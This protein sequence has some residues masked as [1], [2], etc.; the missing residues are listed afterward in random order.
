MQPTLF[1]LPVPERAQHGRNVPTTHTSDPVTS[2]QADEHHRASGK[3]DRHRVLV[4]SMV[5][6]HP[7]N[8]ACELW[9]LAT[10]E[11]RSILGE[12]QEV[13]RRLTDLHHMMDVKQTASRTCTVKGTTQTTWRVADAK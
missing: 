5:I 8:T 11:E 12:M 7:G 3:R 10:P 2:H 13:R 9:Q 1:D 6:R 4:L